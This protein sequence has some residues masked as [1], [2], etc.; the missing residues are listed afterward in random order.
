MKRER[1]FTLI[2]LLVVIA[3]IGILAAILL[4]ALA[5]AREAARRSSC[6]NN[7]KQWG[8]ILKMYSNESKGEKFPPVSGYYYYMTPGARALYPEYWTDANI[9]IC[10]SDSQGSSGTLFNI[11]IGRQDAF[12]RIS[13]CDGPGVQYI[14]DYPASY[15]Y[16]PYAATEAVEFTPYFDAYLD[17][18]LAAL[19][20]GEVSVVDFNCDFNDGTK[21]SYIFP[22]GRMDRDL[23]ASILNDPTGWN[24]TM[25]RMATIKNDGN[26]YSGWTLH[27]V[28]EG[29][30]RF[31]ITDINNPAGSATAQS[32]LALMWDHWSTPNMDGAA[33]TTAFYNHVPGGS[34]VLYM[35]GHVEFIKYKDKYPIGPGQALVT[36]TPEEYELWWM[37][38]MAASMG[39]AYN[40]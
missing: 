30:E 22:Q 17:Q 38:Q 10:P 34:N 8:I 3:I 14:L 25:D 32:E 39:G 27:K 33:V 21:Q 5:R 15:T 20:G 23:S 24:A 6:A 16:F 12:D 31:F 18:F 11:D 19:G 40:P 29:I 37:G 1:G 7:L 4:P 2:E 13:E 36:G 28:R 9:A 26:S 35:D